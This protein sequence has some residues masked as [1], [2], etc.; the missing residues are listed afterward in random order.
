MQITV[1]INQQI[2]DVSRNSLLVQ[3]RN[4]GKKK[5]G[6]KQ[7]RFAYGIHAFH[8]YPQLKKHVSNG[9]LR[10]YKDY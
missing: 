2:L 6:N 9:G 1:K 7:L 5:E 10:T 3:I 4:G 8:S